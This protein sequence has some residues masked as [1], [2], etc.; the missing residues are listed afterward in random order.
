M[1]VIKLKKEITWLNSDNPTW[2]TVG[3]VWNTPVAWVGNQARRAGEPQ[4]YL[5][6][7]LDGTIDTFPSHTAACD[8]AAGKL[9]EI[10]ARLF[11]IEDED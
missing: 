8:A 5:L 10:A 3:H 4:K 7:N 2:P 11:K 9:E 1:K 6:K